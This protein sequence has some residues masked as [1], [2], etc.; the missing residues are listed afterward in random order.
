VAQD[1]QASRR[2]VQRGV[3]V[4]G[5]Y[6]HVFCEHQHSVRF[7]RPR[8]SPACATCVHRNA[9]NSSSASSKSSQGGFGGASV[10]IRAVDSIFEDPDLDFLDVLPP[11]LS[12]TQIQHRFCVCTDAAPGA[13]ACRAAAHA[14]VATRLGRQWIR[15][16]RRW[17]AGVCA[18]ES[19]VGSAMHTRAA[20]IVVRSKA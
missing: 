17:S 9:R 18:D 6:R 16:R 2:D 13:L 15:R 19:K 3:A 11:S 10:A 12:L 5:F 20:F 7:A 8:P 4:F 1:H 14:Y